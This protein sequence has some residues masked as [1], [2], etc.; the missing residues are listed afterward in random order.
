M[1]THVKVLGVVYLAVGACMLLGAVFL[2]LTMGSVAGIVGATAEPQ[3]AAIAIPVLGLAGTASGGDARYFRPAQPHH[4][5]RSSLFQALV[6]NRRYRSFGGQPDQCSAWDG[7][8]R[9]R[10]VGIAE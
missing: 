1:Q 3:D 2:A 10:T 4:W 8:R 6:A 7:G 5:L 9:V